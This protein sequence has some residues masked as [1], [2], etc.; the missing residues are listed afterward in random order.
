[1]RPT[2]PDQKPALKAP[3]DEALDRALFATRVE[4]AFAT[5][6]QRIRA[7]AILTAVVILLVLFGSSLTAF[8]VAPALTARRTASEKLPV[9]AQISAM[10]Q[11]RTRLPGG[12]RASKR[13]GSTPEARVPDEL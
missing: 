2:T 7:R 13:P 5:A 11:R 4:Q 10:S 12:Q 9:F 1:M 3:G 8:V 6:M